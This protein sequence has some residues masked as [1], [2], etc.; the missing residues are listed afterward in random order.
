[1][2]EGQASDNWLTDK[3]EVCFIFGQGTGGVSK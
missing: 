2:L 1:M 3:L